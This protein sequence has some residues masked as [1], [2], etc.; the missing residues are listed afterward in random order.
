[1]RHLRRA[2]NIEYRLSSSKLFQSSEDT[3]H[4]REHTVPSHSLSSSLQP[5]TLIHTHITKYSD[6]LTVSNS[7]KSTNYVGPVQYLRLM[8]MCVSSHLVLKWVTI[9]WPAMIGS[10]FLLYM[11]MKMHIICAMTNRFVVIKREWEQSK[12]KLTKSTYCAQQTNETRLQQLARLAS[13]FTR[14]AR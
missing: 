4:R 5:H 1:M 7:V 10:P 12:K 11:Q 9:A 3:F 2:L 8:L 6:C 13:V 14:Q